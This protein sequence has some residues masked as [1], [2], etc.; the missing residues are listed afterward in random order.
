MEEAIPEL[1]KHARHRNEITLPLEH[2]TEARRVHIRFMAESLRQL[3][4][5]D[6][7]QPGIVARIFIE[8]A[9]RLDLAPVALQPRAN[10]CVVERLVILEKVRQCRAA[11]RLGQM[12]VV[13]H[14]ARRRAIGIGEKL[15]PASCRDG[16][17]K[18]HLRRLDQS[19]LPQRLNHKRNRSQR[20]EVGGLARHL[21]QGRGKHR[22]CLFP[23]LYASR[24]FS[25]PH[26]HV[27]QTEF[28]ESATLRR[29]RLVGCED[30]LVE[31]HVTIG[32]HRSVS[33]VQRC[34]LQKQQGG[35]EGKSVF[36][37]C[38]LAG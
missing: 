5:V 20:M 1:W 3:D 28:I 11:Q 32:S 25:E 29:S 18:I 19:P 34:D 8:I 4:A 7:P 21:R 33:C 27:R 17:E 38:S 10:G 14:I 36:H 23:I 24:D 35:D 26:R 22:R 37:G 16:L 15:F 13:V 31:R 12:D 2:T 30:L 9:R 6:D